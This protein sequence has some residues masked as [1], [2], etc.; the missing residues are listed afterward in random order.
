MSGV[1]GTSSAKSKV[2]GRSIDTAKVWVSYDQVADNVN[3][4]FNVSTVGD[5]DTGLYTIN[6]LTPLA[7]IHYAVSCNVVEDAGGTHS[8]GMDRQTNPSRA[9]TTV[10]YLKMAVINQNLGGGRDC[11]R[12]SV[13]IFG[14]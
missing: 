3:N 6:F 12:N 4:D 8:L 11:T 9:A 1:I 2:I 7:N 13:I 14:D 10:S 5:D